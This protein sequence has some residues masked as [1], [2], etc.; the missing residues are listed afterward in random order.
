MTS[1][2]DTVRKVHQHGAQPGIAE[3]NSQPYDAADKTVDDLD[4][5]GLRITF[6]EVTYQVKNSQNKKETI[7][8]LQNVSGYFSPGQMSVLMGPSGSGKTTLL[9]VLAGR[10]TVGKITGQVLFSGVKPTQPFL[11]RFTGYV[12]QFDSLLH[13]LT[14][15]EMLLYTAELKLNHRKPRKDK[16]ARVDDVI[17]KLQLERC[18]H[19]LIGNQL[20]RGISGGQ[21]KRVNIGL[22]LVTSPRVLFLDEPTSGLDSYTSNEVMKVVKDLVAN[23]SPGSSRDMTICSTIHSPTSTCFK[24]FD[25]LLLLL[26]GEVVFFGHTGVEALEFFENT[27][28]AAG[29]L[30]RG[31]E[32][33]WIVDL[34]THA[35]HEGQGSEMAAAY[36]NSLLAR[37]NAER[38]AVHAQQHSVLSAQTLK[39][40]RTKRGTVTPFWFA[41]FVLFKYRTI[42]N[43]RNPQFLGPRIGDKLIFSLLIMSLYWKVGSNLEPSNNINIAAVCYMW[44]TLPAFGASAY[45]PSIVMERPLF[46]RERNDGLYLAITYLCAKM[47]DELLL[48]IVGTLI[49]SC[50]VYFPLKLG[51]LWVTWWLCYLCTLSIGIVL[52]YLVAALSPSMEIAN[53]ALPAY[54]V[55]LLFFAGFLIRFK[56]IPNYWRWYSYLNFLRY[57]W[58]T[59]MINQFEGTSATINQQQVLKYYGIYGQNR[60]ATLAQEF[61][62]FCGFFVLAWL[63]L[64]FKTHQKR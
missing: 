41:L 48:A 14:V 53:A 2:N 45:V 24:M 8:L 43:Y 62:F 5:T 23:S 21:A 30:S 34:T 29:K 57:A 19:V 44:C 38:I 37:Q 7:N 12:E 25:R 13:S 33:E 58:S 55:T 64:Q 11:R 9:D 54:V 28:P 49:F 1:S 51:G 52:A 31:S 18:Q 36:K 4:S 35:D 15:R 56:D 59:L 16:I 61:T 42:S 47:V 63:A 27:H 20:S 26:R 3:L 22:A 10:K 32:A 60:W 40:L 50:V 46:V 39:E 6:E 17:S